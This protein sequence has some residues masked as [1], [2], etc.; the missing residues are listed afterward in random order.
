MPNV[1]ALLPIAAP[2]LV[3]ARRLAQRFLS[4]P[5]ITRHASAKAPKLYLNQN[6]A[7]SFCLS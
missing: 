6:S 2:V 4:Y 1:G 3:A 7:L 5:L